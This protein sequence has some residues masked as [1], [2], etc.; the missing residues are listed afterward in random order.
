MLLRCV[1]SRLRRDTEASAAHFNFEEMKPENFL[2]VVS[3]IF[4]TGFWNFNDIL[5]LSV[6]KLQAYD[7]K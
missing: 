2:P 4:I 7:C 3:R 5:S 6:R 1:K